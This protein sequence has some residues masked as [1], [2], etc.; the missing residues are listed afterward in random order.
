MHHLKPKTTR[1]EVSAISLFSLQDGDFESSA[2]EHLTSCLDE[3]TTC[4]Y[5][6]T[7]TTT[8]SSNL[9]FKK[10]KKSSGNTI[11]EIND[12]IES[13]CSD[14]EEIITEDHQNSV[15]K[16]IHSGINW[17]NSR[18]CIP[19][20]NLVEQASIPLRNETVSHQEES[21]QDCNYWKQAFRP[22]GVFGQT[23]WTREMEKEEELVQFQPERK[24]NSVE[25]LND[26]HIPALDNFCLVGTRAQLFSRFIIFIYVCVM[27]VVSRM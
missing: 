23:L 20:R 5:S 3:L 24:Y 27:N 14:I 7:T 2:E 11:E 18:D 8:S 13:I 25:G 19:L 21:L 12:E 10:M 26:L 9:I 4:F 22:L 17:R 16:E 15:E 1:K 6:P